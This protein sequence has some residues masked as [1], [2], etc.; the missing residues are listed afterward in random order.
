MRI[1]SKDL[2]KYR[3]ETLSKQGG[4]CAICSLPCPGTK[5]VVDHC[6]TTGE[7]RGVVH[8]GCNSLLG[9]IENNAPR[10]G[11]QDRLASFLHGVVKYLGKGTYSGFIYPTHKTTEEKKLMRAAKL[12]KSR[13]PK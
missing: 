11:V 2:K 13:V 6:H 7:I 1:A 3:E 12:R 8:R 4:K 9:K 10:F 5:A